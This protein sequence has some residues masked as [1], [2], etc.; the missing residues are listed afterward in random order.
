MRKLEGGSLTP[1][2]PP[3]NVPGNPG[4][5]GGLGGQR[6]RMKWEMEDK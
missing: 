3:A 1:L 5:S 6:G 2:P 4:W